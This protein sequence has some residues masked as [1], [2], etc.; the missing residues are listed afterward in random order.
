[1]NDRFKGFTLIPSFLMLQVVL[2]FAYHIFFFL[3][4]NTIKFKNIFINT[5]GN[6]ISSNQSFSISPSHQLLEITDLFLVSIDQPIP[7][8]SYKWSNIICDLFCLATFTQH[9]FKLH[10]CVVCMSTL[11]FFIAQFHFIFQF[12][13]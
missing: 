8:I 4:Q 2:I 3:S 13:C 7:V 9:V 5:K 1:M 6:S 11:S 12:I 10:S